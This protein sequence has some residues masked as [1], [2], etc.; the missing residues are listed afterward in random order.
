MKATPPPSGN[1]R[2]PAAGIGRLS[3]RLLPSGDHDGLRL[4]A[5]D[6]RPD[7]LFPGVGH[8]PPGPQREAFRR[9]RLLPQVLE[10]RGLFGLAI[11]WSGHT[12]KAF[13]LGVR[14]V[15]SLIDKPNLFSVVVAVRAGIVGVVSLTEARASA[16]IGVF[17]SVTTIPAAG[18]HRP[19]DGVRQLDRG[20]GLHAAVA[21]E[22][23]GAHHDRRTGPATPADHVASP[24]TSRATRSS[25]T[26]VGE[27]A[28]GRRQRMIAPRE[29]QT[30][31]GGWR[32]VT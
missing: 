26:V 10:T 11:R 18:R 6:G 24:L 1:R 20:L 13:S 3:R 12:P 31:A 15:S 27:R 30:G 7:P 19:V 5:I 17:I 9:R 2:N 4:V 8:G 21:A 23:R 16:L 29:C 14:L 22:R 32:D 25:K 28:V